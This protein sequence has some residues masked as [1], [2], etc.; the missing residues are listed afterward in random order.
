M[1]SQHNTEVSACRSKVTSFTK[2]Q[3]D[4]K[5]NEKESID[6]KIKMTELLELSDKDFKAVRK[7]ML[8]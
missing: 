2:N 4:L 5:L 1:V 8:Q 6:A 3:K 7:R